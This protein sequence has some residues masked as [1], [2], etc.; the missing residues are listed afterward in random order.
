MAKII[1]L[2]IVLIFKKILKLFLNYVI[3]HDNLS[4]NLKY[5][6][7]LEIVQRKFKVLIQKER[8]INSKAIKAE[9]LAKVG[10]RVVRYNKVRSV[11]FSCLSG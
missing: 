7:K 5:E 9:N 10:G 8:T 11:S 1:V 2:R 6:I 3:N 4:S